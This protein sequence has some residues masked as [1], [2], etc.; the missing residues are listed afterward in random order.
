[1]NKAFKLKRIEAE[2]TQQRLAA[3]VGCPESSIVR[4]E[5]GR[6]TPPEE[7]KARLVAILGGD[8]V[9]MFPRGGAR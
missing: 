3:L 2:L 4:Y 6:G 7:L 9:L 5:T 8:P 1:M